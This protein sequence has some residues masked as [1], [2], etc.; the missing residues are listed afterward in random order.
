MS[1]NLLT[2]HKAT[3]HISAADEAAFMSA[4]MTGG[5]FVVG[6]TQSITLTADTSAGSLSVDAFVA[7][8]S[9]RKVVVSSASGNYTKP[10]SGTTYRHVSAGLLYSKNINSDDVED[11]TFAV[12]TSAT[13]RSTK[14]AAAEDSTGAP[15]TTEIDAATTEAYFELFDLIVSGSVI[16][17][18]NAV[19]Q[20][21][22]TV[23]NIEGAAII[24]RAVV[25]D[26]ETTGNGTSYKYFDF[27]ESAS[28]ILDGV[29]IAVVKFWKYDGT[30]TPI[31]CV[32]IRS[33]HLETSW[34]TIPVQVKIDNVWTTVTYEMVKISSG[35]YS[36][37]I[38]L[39]CVTT[40]SGGSYVIAARDIPYDRATIILW[41]GRDERIQN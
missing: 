32:Y 14:S 26:G 16:E 10:S 3:N 24:A 2:G 23:Q 25:Y 36:G 9:G 18:Q 38:G 13:D 15:E 7:L 33:N 6:D 39:K 35:T 37:Q 1:V 31:Q 8:F 19:Y 12:Y 21:A 4:Y 11:C 20:L 30:E 28:A 40:T 34:K 5:N 29:K 22:H 17:T 41:R 27:D